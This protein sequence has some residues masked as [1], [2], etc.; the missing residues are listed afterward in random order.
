MYLEFQPIKDEHKKIGRIT[1]SGE[2][3]PYQSIKEAK[4]IFFA[5]LSDNEIFCIRKASEVKLSI[6]S[7]KQ[8]PGSNG[9]MEFEG[10]ADYS[11]MN[12]LGVEVRGLISFNVN[13]SNT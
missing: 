4:G 13:N 2:D 3:H 9:Y 7:A 11:E 8:I 10:K 12:A 1:L 6:S 5:S